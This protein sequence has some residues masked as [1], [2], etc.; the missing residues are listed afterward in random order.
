[1]SLK[2]HV[3]F[4]T[5][6]PHRTAEPLSIAQVRDVARCAESLGFQDLWVTENTL[7]ENYSY[8]PFLILTYAAAVTQT[9]RL[10]IAV[11]VLPMHSPIHI[12][13]Q[14]LTLDHISNGRFTLGVGLGRPNDYADFQVPMERRVRR[15][16]EGI[17]LM[18]ALWEKPHADYHGQIYHLADAGIALRPVQ[19]PHP[20]LWLGGAHPDAIRRAAKLGSGWMG[21]GAQPAED[22]FRSVT[23]LQKELEAAG[24]DPR[25]FA[26]SKRIFLAVDKNPA[27]AEAELRRWFTEVYRKPEL[28]DT[29]GIH[30]TPEQV[31]AQLERYCSSGATHLLLNS[32][33]RYE[34]QAQV[35][36]QIVAS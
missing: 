12:A 8:D 10:G 25:G 3:S 11:V 32:V 2:D 15:F 21:G 14:T 27:V 19:K 5:V 20:P 22:F 35:L 23:L 1:M 31:R 17:A 9:I 4:G 24:R 29:A 16:T 6:L 36:A 13:H 26:I 34:E 33:S 18:K 28:L 7:D 30:G